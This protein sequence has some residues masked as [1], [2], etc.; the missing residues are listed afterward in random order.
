MQAHLIAAERIHKPA[1]G[2]AS[3]TAGSREHPRG[4]P[5]HG[6]P[7]YSRFLQGMFWSVSLLQK[8]EGQTKVSPSLL[9]QC[10]QWGTPVPYIPPRVPIALRGPDRRGT[11]H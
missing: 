8:L 6:A 7:D 11:H 9:F 1:M 3:A 4:I 5:G 10:S 2:R